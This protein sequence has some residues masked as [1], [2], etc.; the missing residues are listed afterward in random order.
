[1]GSIFVSRKSVGSWKIGCPQLMST[2]DEETFDFVK[3]MVEYKV[4]A[5][6]NHFIPPEDATPD[7]CQPIPSVTEIQ[8]RDSF[9]LGC[10]IDHL[11]IKRK[12]ASSIP[13]VN[14]IVSRLKSLQ[15]ESRPQIRE[16]L[17]DN[18]FSSCHY[19]K[20]KQSLTAFGSY[21]EVEKKTF[22]TSIVDVVKDIPEDL[23]SSRVL[24]MILTS[25][26]IMLHPESKKHLHPFILVPNPEAGSL[27]SVESFEAFVIPVIVKLFAV[28]KI[29]LRLI[30]L[31]Y[32]P[33][34]V[35]HIPVTT[36]QKDVLPQVQLGLRDENDT[37][38]AETY[39]ALSI[40]VRTFGADALQ[41][42][43]SSA[44]KKIFFNDLSGLTSSRSSLKSLNY[45]V[46]E[47]KDKAHAAT[48]PSRVSHLPKSNHVNGASGSVSDE[49]PQSAGLA[50]NHSWGHD[51]NDPSWLEW[52]SNDG[53]SPVPD[54]DV[55]RAENEAVGKVNDVLIKVNGISGS[56]SKGSKSK[57]LEKNQ[58]LDIKAMDFNSYPEELDNM[59]SEMEPRVNFAAKV[60][61]S[62][63]K[64]D[65]AKPN[66]FAVKTVDAPDEGWNDE[67]E[68]WDDEGNEDSNNQV[69]IPVIE[70]PDSSPRTTTCESPDECLTPYKTP[71]R[72]L[73]PAVAE[74]VFIAD[75]QAT[76]RP[77]PQEPT[78]AEV[79][80]ES[81][82]SDELVGSY[83]PGSR[84][85][86]AITVS[87]TENVVER[88][89]EECVEQ[90]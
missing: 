53:Q 16:I 70:A 75:N 32:L 4:K 10:L 36:M 74:T 43:T 58:E 34:Y 62:E 7:V 64:E 57:R 46:T 40:L 89:V 87:P 77:E 35:N 41:D 85:D 61:V 23:L 67:E 54:V 71:E 29:N 37:L 63:K 11:L 19:L 8:R 12:K 79:L 31:E 22:I 82:K 28:K 47:H 1:M 20:F 6:T 84:E 5:H 45:V 33:F 26:L 76:E 14:N 68:Q 55:V 39:T 59:F 90:Q 17:D 44:R 30:L 25:R 72:P 27:I 48:Q 81:Q 66:L 51:E 42:K 56:A 21:S 24:P 52:G 80:N 2:P 38:V 60:K 13:E 83:I 88:S 9:A 3:K 49:P 50:S 78:L 73:T 18:L 69:T 86:S 15:K 65:Q